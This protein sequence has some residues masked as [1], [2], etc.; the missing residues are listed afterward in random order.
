MSRSFKRTPV[1]S[2]SGKGKRAYKRHLNHRLRH[3]PDLPSG[4]AYR[5]VPHDWEGLHG[6]FSSTVYHTRRGWEEHEASC[7]A[8]LGM[9]YSL[10]EEDVLRHIRRPSAK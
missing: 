1:Q 9:F 4:G 6:W 3:M 5:R 7:W 10:T 8:H 2:Y